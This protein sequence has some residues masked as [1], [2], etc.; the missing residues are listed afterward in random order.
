[1]SSGRA[2]YLDASTRWQVRLDAGVALI[3]IGADHR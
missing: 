2:L 1:V 3:G